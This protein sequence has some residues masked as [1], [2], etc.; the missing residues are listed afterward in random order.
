MARGVNFFLIYVD[1][2]EQPDDIRRHLREYGYPC[3]GLRDPMHTLVAYCRATTTPEAV[4]FGKGRTITYRGRVDDGY[5]DVGQPRSEATTHD[6]AD[7]IESTIS[8]TPVARPRTR[9][10]GC[11]IA[12]LRN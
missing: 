7:A 5:S 6:L 3:P 9:A 2:R 11:S 4:V 10:V 12:D 8:G 1:P